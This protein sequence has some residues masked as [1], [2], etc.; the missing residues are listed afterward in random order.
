MENFENEK[1]KKIEKEITALRLKHKNELDALELKISVHVN[2]FQR[3]RSIKADE[4]ELKYKHKKR[5]LE[6]SQ[7][8]EREEFQRIINNHNNNQSK[9]KYIIYNAL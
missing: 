5:G 4:I 1:E 2:K 8:A 6:N 9:Y 7:N 3:E